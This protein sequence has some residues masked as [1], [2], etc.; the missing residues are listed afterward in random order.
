MNSPGETEQNSEPF[1]ELEEYFKQLEPYRFFDVVMGEDGSSLV[2]KAIKIL[3]AFPELAKRKIRRFGDVDEDEDDD[4]STDK[5]KGD[6][7]LTR[8]VRL[9]C[10]T[11][12]AV[13]RVFNLFPTSILEEGE[14]VSFPLLAALCRET[15]NESIVSFLLESYAKALVRKGNQDV[16]LPLLWLVLHKNPSLSL[17]RQLVDNFPDV[18]AKE[19]PS[20]TAFLNHAY[21]GASCEVFEYLVDIMVQ[22]GVSN[23]VFSSRGL[24]MYQC[25]YGH[26]A[27]MHQD[28][29]KYDKKLASLL[30]H[31]K[32]FSFDWWS[33]K[34]A[35]LKESWTLW[36]ESLSKSQNIKHFSWNVSN[37]DPWHYH[38]E[39]AASFRSFLMTTE[40]LEELRILDCWS[41]DRDDC[42]KLF[43]GSVDGGQDEE[44]P[45]D[46]STCLDYIW[47]VL[48]DL[49]EQGLPP[50]L[51]QLTFEALYVLDPTNFEHIV[52]ESTV[53]DI[54]ISNVGFQG[55]WPRIPE[56][57]NPSSA[58]KTLAL[59]DVQF[60]SPECVHS[61][62][63][64]VALLPNLESFVLGLSEEGPYSNVIDISYEVRL[65]IQNPNLLELTLAGMTGT[66]FA[67]FSEALRSNTT[68]KK[69]FFERSF[70]YDT[71]D[72]RRLEDLL[73]NGQSTIER[74]LLPYFGY[75]D[76]IHYHLFLNRC[77]RKKAQHID[78]TML[79][80]FVDLLICVESSSWSRTMDV[81]EAGKLHVDC[82]SCN[83][84]EWLNDENLHVSIYID[85][86]RG[87]PGVWSQ[88]ALLSSSQK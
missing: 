32:Y 84:D 9:H 38:Q 50:T 8:L 73:K 81:V 10:T 71:G 60:K 31:L 34:N 65:L 43:Y 51:K 28:R 55:V 88:A 15:I 30:S 12:D 42:T 5:A 61:F 33:R 72:R 75:N 87:N 26:S 49:R 79:S 64:Q 21:V 85:L 22:A 83:Y 40:T 56:S 45:K 74:M 47:P 78:S 24:W 29:P 67:D 77:G 48:F 27:A 52:L 59:E 25:W 37:H 41:K 16:A 20:F 68:L 4:G 3:E 2:Q 57:I 7:P 23:F 76:L 6:L 53:K 62:L 66:V 39:A 11:L 19:D 36:M 70:K 86:L 17:V 69:L 35:I 80:T 18:L 58:M 82:I 13:R 63:T 54:F 44:P 46:E 14:S 1:S